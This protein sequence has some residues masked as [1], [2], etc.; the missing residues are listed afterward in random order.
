M[1]STYPFII[2]GAGY[3]GS[4]LYRRAKE[5][6]HPAFATS[7]SPETHLPFALP[8]DRLHFDLEN[9]TSWGNLP[10]P[11]QLIWCFPALPKHQALAFAKKMHDR[12]CRL[13]LLG[14]TSAYPTGEDGLIDETATIKLHLPRVTVEEHIRVHHGATVLRLAGLYGP[15]RNVL[16]WIRKGRIQNTSRYVNLIHIE[17]VTEVC[18]AACTQADAGASYIVSDGTPRQ[19]SEICRVANQRWNV[20]LPPPAVSSDVGKKLSPKKLLSKLQ[21]QLKHPDLYSALDQ[22]EASS[23]GPNPDPTFRL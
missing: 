8:E 13:V 6:G 20:A 7:R 2:L 10:H 18:L 1:S 15:G 4:F 22:I 11:A 17:D 14:S 23:I 19:W 3:T 16:D 5:Y 21:Y 12:Q 9:P